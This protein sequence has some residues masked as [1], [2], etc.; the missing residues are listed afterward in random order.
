LF[1]VG[2]NSI[3]IKPEHSERVFKIFQRLHTK[4][5]DD[6]TG[7]GLAISKRIVERHGGVIWVDSERTD[8][9][10]SILQ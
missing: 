4:E 6:G 2:D 7:I 10:S 3:G 5:K 9:T 1:P 8:G